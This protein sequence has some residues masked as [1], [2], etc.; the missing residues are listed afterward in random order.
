MESRG[1]KNI[2]GLHTLLPRPTTMLIVGRRA[3][4]DQHMLVSQ[5]AALQ[6]GT[7]PRAK[8]AKASLI[9]EQCA[10][11]EHHACIAPRSD[12]RVGAALDVTLLEHCARISVGDDTV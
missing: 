4:G 3:P 10:S 11:D 8:D 9:V 1:E 2:H 7:L 6:C 12:C 5:W